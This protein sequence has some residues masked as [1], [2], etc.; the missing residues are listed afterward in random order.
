MYMAQDINP[1][2]IEEVSNKIQ[3]LPSNKLGLVMPIVLSFRKSNLLVRLEEYLEL[4]EIIST[5]DLNEVPMACGQI[6]C[7]VKNYYSNGIAEVGINKQFELLNNAE[8][9][10]LSIL[11]ICIVQNIKSSLLFHEPYIDIT[12]EGSDLLEIARQLKINSQH[13]L[14]K[15]RSVKLGIEK[16]CNKKILPYLESIN[17]INTFEQNIKL[18]TEGK[19]TLDTELSVL[20]NEAK[21]RKLSVNLKTKEF[22]QEGKEIENNIKFCCGLVDEYKNKQPVA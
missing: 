7:A 8:L 9:M 5:Y 22:L 14:K 10:H 13:L 16:F 20:H 11:L 12:E 15:T 21:N 18:L 17:E 1:N 19:K 4:E 6:Y 3:C 2:L